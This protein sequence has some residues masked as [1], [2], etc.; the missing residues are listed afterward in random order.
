MHNNFYFVLKTSSLFF[1]WFACICGWRS[2]CLFASGIMLYHLICSPLYKAGVVIIALCAFCNALLSSSNKWSFES[3][4]LSSFT[5][6]CL[7]VKF[8]WNRFE[9]I[10]PISYGFAVTSS[11]LTINWKQSKCIWAWRTNSYCQMY[12]LVSAKFLK[13]RL[14]GTL[15]PRVYKL[16]DGVFCKNANK[17][18]KRTVLLSTQFIKNNM[19]PTICFYIC[20]I[21]SS[22]KAY[23]QLCMKTLAGK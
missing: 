12:P 19:S 21:C 9:R 10:L 13:M 11:N 17:T 14:N 8:L 6:H 4:T 18:R 7:T 3:T 5:C 16:E 23:V 15:N 22:R 20:I 2:F 1:N